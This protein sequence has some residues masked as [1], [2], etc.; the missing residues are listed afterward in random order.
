MQGLK[1][2]VINGMFGDYSYGKFE[3][4]TSNFMIYRMTGE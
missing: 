3:E 1:W 2:T 4:E